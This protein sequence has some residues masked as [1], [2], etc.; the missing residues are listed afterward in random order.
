MAT[1]II[2]TGID[3]K[4]LRPII[5]RVKEKIKK[6]PVVIDLFKEYDIDIS[7]IDMIPVCFADISVS[8]RTDHAVIYLNISL[9]DTP[10]EIDHYL[11][12]EIVHFLQQTTG[13]KPTKG[14][15]D[16]DYLENEYEIEGFQ[17]QVEYMADT[18]D[19][20]TAEDYVD[21]VLDHHEVDNKKERKEKKEELLEL[22][23]KRIHK[24]KLI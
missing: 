4:K 15:D 8:A 7:E 6:H 1:D 24:F 5:N 14:A 16:G 17:K 19:E 22:I 12:H 21:Q 9:L 2:T 18:R 10:E 20:D 13:D 11:T 3:Q 23:A